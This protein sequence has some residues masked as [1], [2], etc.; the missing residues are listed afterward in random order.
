MRLL[1]FSLI[2]AALLT[3]LAFLARNRMLGVQGRWEDALIALGLLAL[4]FVGHAMFT[5][6]DHRSW[7]RAISATARR[8][9]WVIPFVAIYLLLFAK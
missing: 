1:G 7:K 3:T 9:L 8:F 5:F 2:L 4:G 6:P